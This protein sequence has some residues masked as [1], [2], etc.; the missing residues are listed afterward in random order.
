MARRE[1][2]LSPANPLHDLYRQL[3]RL[4]AT[5]PDLQNKYKSQPERYLDFA[6]DFL[7]ANYTGSDWT[8]LEKFL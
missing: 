5:N 2:A 4:Y 1:R 7:R 8:E 6:N 3:I